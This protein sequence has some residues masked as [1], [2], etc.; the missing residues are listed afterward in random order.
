MYGWRWGGGGQG[1][2][3]KVDTRVEYVVEEVGVCK[4]KVLYFYLRA[5]SA[6]GWTPKGR[7]GKEKYFTCEATGG[8]FT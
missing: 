4:A 1:R 5:L 6:K 3:E 2:G 7:R 8:I